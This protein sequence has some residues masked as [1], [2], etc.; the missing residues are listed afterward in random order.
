LLHGLGWSEREVAELL[1]VHRS[2]VRRHR[3]RGITKL[4]KSMEVTTHA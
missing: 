1:G 4:R 3:E 2:T